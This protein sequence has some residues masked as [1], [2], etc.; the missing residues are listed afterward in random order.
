MAKAKKQAV[1]SQKISRS[2]GTFTA[3]WSIPSA[4]KKGKSKCGKT[5]VQFYYVQNGKTHYINWAHTAALPTKATYAPTVTQ[6]KTKVGVRVRLH[7]SKGWGAWKVAE[8]KL[9]KPRNVSWG[10]PELDTES[11]KVSSAGSWDEDKDS[12]YHWSKV[13]S[14]I[15]RTKTV[16]GTSSTSIVS[17]DDSTGTSRTVSYDEGEVG[18]LKKGDCIRYTWYYERIGHAGKTSNANGSPKVLYVGWAVDPVIDETQ[19]VVDNDQD[20]VQVPFGYESDGGKVVSNRPTTKFQLQYAH[21]TSGNPK[22]IPEDEW[23]D[24]GTTDNGNGVALTCTVT[25]IKATDEGTHVW[26]RIK[27]TNDYEAMY[28]ASEPVEIR[29]LYVDVQKEVIEPTTIALVGYT[30]GDDGE[31]EGLTIAWNDT[32]YNGTRIA[33]STFAFAL[34]SNK[35]PD[36]FDVSDD[37]DEGEWSGTIDGKAMTYEHHATMW[38]KGL[39]E[40]TRYYVWLRRISMDDDTQHTAWSTSYQFVTGATAAGVTLSAPPILAR[41]TSCAFSW[42]VGGSATQTAWT[43]YVND[44]ALMSGTDA[45]SGCTL[46]AELVPEGDGFTAYVAVTCGLNVYTSDTVSVVVR[47]VP[48]VTIATERVITAKGHTATITAAQG[49]TCDIRLTSCGVGIKTPASDVMQYAGELV[50]SGSVTIGSEGS[51]TITYP[52]DT[53]L[54]D[55]AEY[56]LTV[57]PTLDGLTGAATSPEWDGSNRHAVTWAHQALAPSQDTTTITTDPDDLTATITPG[58]PDGYAEGDAWADTDTFEV[59]RST[60]DGVTLIASGLTLGQ[61]VTDRWAPY[62]PE[63]EPAYV[64]AT[65]TADGDRDW[66]EFGYDLECKHVR[67]DWAGGNAAMLYNLELK[68][69]WGKDFESRGYLDGTRDGW[70]GATTTRKMTVS[71][72]MLRDGT[73]E[74]VEALRQMAQHLG[75]VFVRTPEGLAF[76]ANVEVS[77]VSRSSDSGLLGTSFDIEEVRCQ[78]HVCDGNDIVES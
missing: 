32:T 54:V 35:E 67:F 36:T 39:D 7:N 34:K 71:A 76:A 63:D 60:P 30:A 21:T 48:T 13:T 65:V 2:G 58:K 68:D 73:A 56:V 40:S 3:T 26:V 49:T 17:K 8:F 72:D 14:W 45:S 1:S 6:N 23:A 11:G 5:Q 33:F 15:E 38:L 43:L 29:S 74:E 47:D 77:E 20:R 44:M 70:W 4:A 66:D 69:S 27:A 61:G 46:P 19:I 10:D 53:I 37:W 16:D 50:W 22:L 41:D 52:A 55:G 42:L 12:A 25:A 75:E 59:Y 64:I 28:G 57:T 62:G 78:E 31:S 18:T 51:A 24:V 9:S